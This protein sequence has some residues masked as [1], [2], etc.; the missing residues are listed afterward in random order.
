MGA[1][2]EGGRREGRA[3]GEL[4]Q[5][6]HALLEAVHGAMAVPYR[7]SERPACS[8]LSRR[9]AWHFLLENCL[10]NG[11]WQYAIQMLS[12]Y[13]APQ[14]TRKLNIEITQRLITT[15]FPAEPYRYSAV[16]VKL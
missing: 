6:V 5:A 12:R 1:D 8:R 14:A 10:I 16:W 7:G 3:V 13:Y 9:G 4:R 2:G 15:S 11:P